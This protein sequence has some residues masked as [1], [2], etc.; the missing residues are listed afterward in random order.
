[1]IQYALVGYWSG[2]NVGDRGDDVTFLQELL[3]QP[4][5]GIWHTR[6]EEAFLDFVEH[7]TNS[8]YCIAAFFPKNWFSNFMPGDGFA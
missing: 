4:S 7:A 8:W 5:T 2:L 3:G 6:D 1:M